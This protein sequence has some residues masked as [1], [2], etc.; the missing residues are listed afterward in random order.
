MGPSVY[1]SFKFPGNVNADDWEKF[2]EEMP[3]N[4]VNALYK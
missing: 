2:K 1:I 4:G 3:V